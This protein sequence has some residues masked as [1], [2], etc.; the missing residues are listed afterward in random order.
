VPTLKSSDFCTDRNIEDWLF[1][2]SQPYCGRI[3][4]LVAD[5]QNF[6]KWKN[7]CILWWGSMA[8][9]VKSPNFGQ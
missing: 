1:E 4:L 9:P 6:R 3:R 2:G 7:I 8:A 5:L